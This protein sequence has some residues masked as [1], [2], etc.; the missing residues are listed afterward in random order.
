VGFAKSEVFTALKIQVEV[1]WAVTPCI[2]VLGDQLF[3]APCFLHLHGEV[4]GA[5][6]WK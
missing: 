1:F 3:G 5:G 2:V 4:P 6:K